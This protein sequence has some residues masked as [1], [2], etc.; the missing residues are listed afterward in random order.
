MDVHTSQVFET[1]NASRWKRFKWGSRFIFFLL[2]LSLAIIII[3]SIVSDSTPNIKM[4]G[5]A[6][7]AIQE[8]NDFLSDHKK[9]PKNDKGFKTFINTKWAKGKGCGLAEPIDPQVSASGI[10]N[11]S[12]GIRSAFYVAWDPQSFF[13]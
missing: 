2:L 3:D 12:A 9:Y 7:R 10:K 1:T 5:A 13:S 4:E 11:T 8:R 6:K